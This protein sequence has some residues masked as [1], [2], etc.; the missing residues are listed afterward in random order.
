MDS[1]KKY[2]QVQTD[3]GVSELIIREGKALDVQPPRSIELIGKI[4]APASWWK[5]RKDKVDKDKCHVIVT[6]N[7]I[8]L[9]INEDSHYEHGYISGRLALDRECSQ[10]AIN[11]PDMLT[12]SK[13][14][15]RKLK[16]NEFLFPERQQWVDLV[17]A[18]MR[19]ESNVQVNIRDVKE[20]SGDIDKALKV[21]VQNQVPNDFKLKTRLYGSER[22]EYTV[23]LGAEFQSHMVKFYMDS[24]ELAFMLSTQAEKLINDNV[25]IFEDDGIAIIRT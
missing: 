11:D 2:I 21:T 23:E 22:H 12:D 25:K 19:F 24:S 17:S 18:L 13:T 20:T 16:A 1:Q 14:L 3:K 7:D 5:V 9:H 15:A 8:T 4:D 6:H 10:F